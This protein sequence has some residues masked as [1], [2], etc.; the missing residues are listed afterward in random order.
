MPEPELADDADRLPLAHGEAHAVDGLHVPDGTAEE[1]PPYWKPD[2]QVL[3]AG[4]RTGAWIARRGVA[5]R[6]GGEQRPRVR[7]PRV[8]EHLGHSARFDDLAPLHHDH[9]VGDAAHDVEV[10]GNK[11]HRHAHLLLQVLQ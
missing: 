2:F 1:A 9:V 7:M 5:L 4:D 6:L 10:V 3:G 11:Q 8:G